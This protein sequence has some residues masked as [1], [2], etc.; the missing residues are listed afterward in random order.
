MSCSLLL[1][2][3]NAPFSQTYFLNLIL[4]ILLLNSH[5]K[6][7]KSKSKKKIYVQ[8]WG[9]WA[10]KAQ[11]CLHFLLT[12]E[13][14][15]QPPLRLVRLIL[16]WIKCG[17]FKD[18]TINSLILSCQE[19]ELIFTLS[20]YELNVVTHFSPTEY[21]RSDDV[22]LLRVGH[23]KHSGFLPAPSLRSFILGK[24][25]FMPWGQSSSLMESFMW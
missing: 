17:C 13:Y 20:E 12:I 4:Q 16:V 15:F 25:A 1:L 6:L 24:L 2:R 19:M 9:G 21:R 8:D 11:E 22:L 18:M 23:K 7:G 10:K 14:W 3:P 5:I